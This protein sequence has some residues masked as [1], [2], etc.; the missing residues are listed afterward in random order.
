MIQSTIGRK[1]ESTNV[2]IV[3][4]YINVLP[5][6]VNR[7]WSTRSLTDIDSIIIHQSASTGSLK[8]VNAYHITPSP[9]NHISHAGAPHICYHYVIDRNGIVY[10]V[11]S[12][13]S[14]VWHCKG[15][16]SNSI[17]I[18]VLGNFSGPSYNGS[19]EPTAE[20]VNSLKKLILAYTNN[21]NEEHTKGLVINK[22]K[23]FGHKD[24]GKEN[25]PGNVLY[26]FLQD[27]KS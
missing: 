21:E 13:T 2:V 18:L 11:N 15:Q 10:N 4:D 16:N 6:H 20:Q 14:V 27:Y 24:F 22:S 23:V 12:L 9:N 3:K 19:Q 8:N 7:R 25:C 26:S 1:M 17:G 5:W